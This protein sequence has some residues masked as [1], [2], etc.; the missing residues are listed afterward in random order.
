MAYLF[1]C[2]NCENRFEKE[3]EPFV[4][5]QDN[6]CPKCGSYD[7]RNIIAPKTIQFKGT[8]FHETDYDKRGP[9]E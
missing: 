1:L 7:T 5:P 4:V 9:K 8:G 6:Q 3:S 2:I